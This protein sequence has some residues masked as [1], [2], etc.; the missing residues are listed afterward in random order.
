MFDLHDKVMQIYEIKRQI[1]LAIEEKK[2]DI[3]SDMKFADYP[4][5]IKSIVIPAVGLPFAVS[6]STESFPDNV[7]DVVVYPALL[8]KT[9]TGDGSDSYSDAIHT[10]AIALRLFE[11]W[12]QATSLIIE[13]G[14]TEIGDSA[15]HGW[16]NATSLVIPET[17]T[18]IGDG[19]F[20]NW[21]SLQSVTCRAAVPPPSCGDLPTDSTAPI[22]V[23][24]ASVEAYKTAWPDYAARITAIV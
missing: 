12:D 5:A 23:P 22:Y 19:A 4:D 24:A 13:R 14:F 9:S 6:G 21:H 15:F 2:P 10:T 20:A 7:G 17:V 1:L 16:N 18:S 11:E 8:M 3:D